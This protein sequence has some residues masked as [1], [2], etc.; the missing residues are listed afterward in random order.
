MKKETPLVSTVSNLFSANALAS[1]MLLSSIVLNRGLGPELK[2]EYA[3][4]RLILTLYAPLFLMGYPGGI[5]YYSL[6]KKLDIQKF[7]VT[8]V[9]VVFVTGVIAS[10]LIYAMNAYGFFG[11]ILQQIEPRIFNLILSS[12]PFV[13]LNAYFQ[14]VFYAYRLFRPANQRDI[15]G[16]SFIMVC[17][18]LLWKIG[19]LSLYTSAI[20][21]LS[22]ILL[23]CLLNIV[24]IRRLFEVRFVYQGSKAFFPWKYG[25]KDFLNQVV[26]K[27][28]DK[29]DQIFLGF[30]ISPSGFG[31][32]TAGIALAS[33]AG[34]IPGSYTNVFYAQ[35]AS[36]PID[37]GVKLFEKAMRITIY[38]SIVISIGLAIFASSLVRMLYGDAFISAAL[39]VIFYLPGLI[40]QVSA[41]LTMKFFAAQGKPL[42]ISL[43][44][45][46]GLIFS[47]PFYFLLIPR[48]G[49][50]GAAIS[51]SIGYFVSFTFS[52]WLLHKQYSFE[53]REILFIERSDILMIKS[54]IQNLMSKRK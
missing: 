12:I 17:I 4:L 9:C 40:F 26:A 29:F 30:L 51:S 11:N 22:S 37:K 23:I 38:I 19:Q 41:R 16:A 2:G 33:L 48:M 14:R 43:V 3:S 8:G 46:I 47:A 27:S 10:T 24:Y 28:N 42:M 5:L 31:I 52:L 25:I 50:V 34:S 20:V 7:F 15:A 45:L 36:L 35:I 54:K 49:L 13:F 6:K 44:Y 21:L 18:A 53:V 39:V 32:Y 1:I